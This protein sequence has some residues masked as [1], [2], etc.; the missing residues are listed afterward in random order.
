[1]LVLVAVCC[2]FLCISIV[3]FSITDKWRAQN[4]TRVYAQ[5]LGCSIETSWKIVNCLKQGRSFYELGNAEFNPQIGSIPWGP[6]LENNFTF[7]GDNWYEGW[8]E[9]DWHFL[10][11]APEDLIKKRQFNSR[12]HYMTSITM[13]EAA[14]VVCEYAQCKITMIYMQM[15]ID[16]FFF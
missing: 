15:A 11:E 4:T 6:V 7:P 13:Q 9:K 3:E 12:L 10:N 1:M 2:Y 8:R 14:Y 16:F 5:L